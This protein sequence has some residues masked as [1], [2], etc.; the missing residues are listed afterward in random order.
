M[1]R[2]FSR[3][4]TLV[5]L[6]IAV[7]AGILVATAAMLLARNAVLLLQEEARLASTQ[8]AVSTAIERIG[9]DIEFAGRKASPNIFSDPRVCA[10]P[11]LAVFPEGLRRLAPIFVD[12]APFVSAEAAVNGKKPERITIAGDLESGER[13]DVRAILP[14]PSGAL[15]YLQPRG[16]AVRRIAALSVENDPSARLGEIFQMGRILRI[17]GGSYDYLGVIAAFS[18]TQTPTET[19]AVL[20]RKT[21]ALPLSPTSVLR[22]AGRGFFAGK[23]AHVISRVRYEIR[24]LVAEPTY[25]DW[26]GP[27]NNVAGEEGRTEL[28]RVELDADDHEMP[29]SLRIMA[30][31]AVDLRFGL[32]ALTK[33]S[34]SDSPNLLHLPI[35]EDPT[36]AAQIHTLAGAPFDPN[37]DPG[38]VRAVAVRLSLRSRAPDRKTSL[39]G[40][41]PGRSYRFEVPNAKTMERFARV[42]TLEREFF[43]KNLRD[44]ARP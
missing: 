43:L 30:E 28:I 8:I 6:L 19:I 20:L 21:P 18:I 39:P 35:S 9:A 40:A 15:V 10:E 5:E 22:C 34:T 41:P 17:D 26:I 42:R 12:A 4:F 23:S 25:A 13:F 11:G 44:G 32:K 38:A 31:Y 7:S 16:A 3:G 33:T 29:H 1:R 37:A 36:V 27:P 14:G 2:S 24:S